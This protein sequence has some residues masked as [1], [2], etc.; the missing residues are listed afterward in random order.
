MRTLTLSKIMKNSLLLL[1][2]ACLL[3][4]NASRAQTSAAPVVAAAPVAVNA[5]EL[6]P[7]TPSRPAP[8]AKNERN[9]RFQFEGIPYSDVV[10]RF[11]QMAGKPLLADTNLTGT[12]T[13]DDPESL[14]LC[15][16]A[17]HAEPH[18]GDE[19]DDAD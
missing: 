9:I 6:V 14:Q 1:I 12:L 15:R 4:L 3:P 18:P 8:P 13:Y 7:A 5:A 10:E 2:G 17:R 11:A 16:G 19:G